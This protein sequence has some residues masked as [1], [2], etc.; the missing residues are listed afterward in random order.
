MEASINIT[1]GYSIH[2]DILV[3]THSVDA[4]LDSGASITILQEDTFRNLLKTHQVPGNC[5]L[6][7]IGNKPVMGKLAENVPIT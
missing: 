3:D 5:K 2:C 7:G 4:L 6:Q 1:L